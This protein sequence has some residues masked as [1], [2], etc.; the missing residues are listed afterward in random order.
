[1]L[2]YVIYVH[3]S[4]I[5]GITS[6]LKEELNAKHDNQNA[7]SNSNSNSNS[8]ITTGTNDREVNELLQTLS[9]CT[10]S[11]LNIANVYYCPLIYHTHI[12]HKR[13]ARTYLCAVC[14]CHL[15]IWLYRM[16]WIYQRLKQ[17]IYH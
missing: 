1:M 8:N 15:Y 14:T 4:G 11:L 5:L 9:V 6:M 13:I 2:C 17:V 16:Y 12:I 7:T 3:V 10:K